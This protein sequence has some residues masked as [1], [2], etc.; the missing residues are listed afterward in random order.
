MTDNPIPQWLN[1]AAME[2]DFYDG[3]I[4]LVEPATDLRIG[5]VGIFYVDGNSYVKEFGHDELISANP[6]YAP[7]PL[8]EDSRCMGRVIGKL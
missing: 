5:E 7:I 4:L 8:N 6:A 2:P 1:K 3:D